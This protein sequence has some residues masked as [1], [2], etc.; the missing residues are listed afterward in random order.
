M[1][2]GGHLYGLYEGI[3]LPYRGSNYGSVVPDRITIFWGTLTRDFPDDP[4][5]ED[6]VRKTV[7]HEIAHYFGLDEHDLEHTRVQ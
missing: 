6:E 1:H 4:A 7:Y 2:G 3:A 5:L